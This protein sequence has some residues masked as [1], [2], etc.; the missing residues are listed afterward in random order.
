MYILRMHT[1]FVRPRR[2]ANIKQSFLQLMCEDSRAAFGFV[3]YLIVH[4][5]EILKGA[6]IVD[7]E[8]E[9]TT[10]A[11]NTHCIDERNLGIEN[12]PLLSHHRVRLVPNHVLELKSHTFDVV[13][14]F[15][16]AA[17]NNYHPHQESNQVEEVN[18]LQCELHLPL[19]P[20]NLALLFKLDLKN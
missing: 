10:S 3:S 9:L 8:R 18:C 17:R 15:H 20:L 16:L 4:A 5:I 1:K 7:I 13:D 6:A 19:H 14:A 11:Q 2:A 12:P